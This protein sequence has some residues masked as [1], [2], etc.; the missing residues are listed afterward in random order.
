MENLPEMI[1]CGAASVKP[2]A[3]FASVQRC[4]WQFQADGLRFLTGVS[5]RMFLDHLEDFG[6]HFYSCYKI[7]ADII[8]V[9]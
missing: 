6:F 4:T 2:F 9:S 3:T 8:F 1:S 7:L 5:V